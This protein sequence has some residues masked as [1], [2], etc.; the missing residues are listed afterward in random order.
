[1]KHRLKM[2][3]ITMM[4]GPECMWGTFGGGGKWEG[5]ENGK[6]TEG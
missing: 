3:M 1:M 6:D 4:M 5:R 2:M